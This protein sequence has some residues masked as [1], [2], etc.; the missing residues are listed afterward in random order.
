MEQWREKLKNQPTR[1]W[2]RME[3][4]FIIKELNIDR[5]RFYEYSKMNFQKV[6]K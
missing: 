1:Y 6:I 5:Y 2:S 4:E 3:I